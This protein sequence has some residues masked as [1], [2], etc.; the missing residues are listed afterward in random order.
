MPLGGAYAFR[1]VEYVPFA[2]SYEAF[3]L[4]LLSTPSLAFALLTTSERAWKINRALQ[5]SVLALSLVLS[6]LNHELQRFMGAQLDWDTLFTYYNVFRTPAVIWDALRDDLGGSYSALWIDLV[7]VGFAALAYFGSARVPRKLPLRMQALIA[8]LFVLIGCVQ[9]V[10][11]LR[12][13]GGLNRKL[14]VRPPLVLL[15]DSAREGMPDERRYVDVQAAIAR[16]QRDWLSQ[17][18]GGQHRFDDARYPLRH[19][20]LTPFPDALGSRK[21]NIILLSLETFR[22]RDMG[23]FNPNLEHSP[24]PF[25]DSLARDPDSAYYTRYITNGLPTIIA[26]MSMHTSTL[27]HSQRVVASSFTRDALDA[28]PNVLRERGYRAMFFTASDPDWDNER[29]WLT[30]W[31]DE[32][33]YNR[34]FRERDR[35]TFL[36]A[37]ARIAKAG[38]AGQPF[39]ATIVSINNHAPFR[40]PNHAFD[41]DPGRSPR[42]R[43][44]NTMHYTDDVVRE[45][46]ERVRHE[47]WF[48][49]TVLIVTGDHAYDLGERGRVIGHDN[50]RHESTWVPLIIHGRNARLPRGEQ[51]RVASHIDLAPTIAQLAGST[52]PYAFE[53]HSLLEPS[54]GEQLAIAVRN[55]NFALEA[56]DFSAYVPAHGRTLVYDATDRVQQTDDRAKSK[57]PALAQALAR[58]RDL[59]LVTDWAYEHDK[60]AP[61]PASSASRSSAVVGSAPT[62][63]QFSRS[64]S[65]IDAATSVPSCSKNPP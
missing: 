62:T 5:I 37:A 58:A 64:P 13:R 31:Y 42:N 15:W 25:L 36:D 44:H 30:R 8:G 43:I 10:M 34:E 18:G 60:F 27:P 47:P 61:A 38:R 57:S 55:G 3:G 1:P 65:W 19:R 40:T 12:R 49:D 17:D 35:M 11:G 39:L 20:R 63:L 23:A 56:T 54:T 48:D 32:T 45:F 6:Q 4:F 52:G 22:A 9:P 24:T 7:A 21:P 53:G 26:F 29:T 28:F 14:R 41:V 46:V 51:A 50:L 59:S 16:W 2:V 33:H